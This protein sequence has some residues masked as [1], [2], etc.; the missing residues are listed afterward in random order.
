MNQRW[1][2][3]RD[4][5]RPAG[6][7]IDTRRYGV[8]VVQERDAR[9]FVVRNH[10][11]SS[12]VAARLSVGLWRS[13]GAVWA[14]ELVGVAVFSVGVQPKAIT[15]WCGLPPEQG[16][17]LG[18]FV[19]LDDVPA[20]GETWFLKRAFDEVLA[21]PKL[22]DV[23]AVLSY[24]DPVRRTTMDGEVVTP[25]HVGT[26]YQAQNGRYLGRAERL[27]LELDPLG[28]VV[29][30]RAKTKIRK[31][32]TG[33]GPEVDRLV[34]AGARRPARG[35]DLDV[36]LDEVLNAPPFRKLRHPGNHTYAWTLR[37]H[38]WREA[39]RLM[40]PSAGAY[41]KVLDAVGAD[42]TADHAPPCA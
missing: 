28:R 17:E 11:A 8:E 22:S 16:I 12:F 24:S 23:R 10:Y 14:P 37:R 27:T 26:I 31:G 35:E 38:G 40:A 6:E 18:R 21:C 29:P 9:A 15:R 2:D 32:E 41:P 7:P 39:A 20:N 33:A 1:R 34:A 36:W 3:H 19:L 30:G 4:S 13:R 5:Y 25:G 42:R